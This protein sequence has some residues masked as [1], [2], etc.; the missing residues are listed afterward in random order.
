MKLFLLFIIK[1]YWAVIP[2]HKRRKCLFR[3][4][5][6]KHVYEQTKAQGLCKG[7]MAFRYRF[8]NCRSGFQLFDSPIDGSRM[9]I[10]PNTQLLQ[11]HEIAERFIDK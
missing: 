8:Q 7:L 5:C 2:K 3:V 1:V 6:S 4:S 9:M 10:L 11:T